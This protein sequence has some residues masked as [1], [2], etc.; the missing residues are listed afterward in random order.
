MYATDVTE[1]VRNEEKLRVSEARYRE[2]FE[3]NPQLSW[4]I[5]PELTTL[6]NADG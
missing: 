5:S 2:L 6:N 3:N 1:R 4:I